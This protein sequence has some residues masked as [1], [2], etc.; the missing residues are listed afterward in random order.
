[1]KKG[2]QGVCALMLTTSLLL[3]TFTACGKKPEFNADSANNTP[4][5]NQNTQNITII[6]DNSGN[7]GS[8]NDSA[9]SSGTNSGSNY[10][11][12]GSSSGSS[13][14]SY[15][16][17]SSSGGSSS[18]GS[19]NGNSGNSA[20]GG[21]SSSNNNSSSPSVNKTPAT[22]G[23]TEK[24]TRPITAK[25]VDVEK[26]LNSAKLNPM[27]TGDSDLEKRVDEVLDKV[28][29]PNMSTYEKVRAVYN[30]LAR[31]NTYIIK[32]APRTT[33]KT[34]ISPYDADVVAR[35][36]TILK[37]KRGNCID[38]SAAFMVI[39]RRIGLECYLVVGKIVDKW[40]TESMHGWNVMRINGKDYG[41]DPEADFRFADSGQSETK[42]WLFCVDDPV[43]FDQ[44]YTNIAVSSFKK[45]KS[46]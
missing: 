7:T 23:P 28:T 22:E 29:T 13:S 33:E 43:K 37:N 42:Y 1:M 36:K 16:S 35:A 2:L 20:S 39:T 32:M 27:T 14:G 41:F 12:G 38:F 11:S 10:S 24:T 34:Y 25:P 19:Y 15:S 40:G 8:G 18:G 17:G 5:G 4:A 3:A 26:V 31:S 6:N 21:S 46:F 45:F 30:Y 44:R 9:S